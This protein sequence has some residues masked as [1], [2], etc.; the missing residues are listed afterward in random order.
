[1]NDIAEF[2]IH[3]ILVALDAST[4]SLA[5]LEEAAALASAMQAEL[6]GL[7][8]EDINLVRIA[9]L[10]FVRQISFPYGAE[11]RMSSERI[12]RELKAQAE[13]ARQALASAAGRRHTRWSFRTVRGQVT[14]EILAAASQ[15]DLVLLGQSG[16]SPARAVGST[17]LALIAASPGAF[18]LVPQEAPQTGPI[19]VL[20]D[21]SIDSPGDSRRALEAA[22]RLGVAH[23]AALLVLV[24]G[25]T[26]EACDAIRQN[27]REIIGRR[28]KEFRVRR[29]P[30]ATPRELAQVL[31]TEHGRLLV[32]P[33]SS[34]LAQEA[35]I[36][37]LLELTRSPLLL[38]R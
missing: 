1:M 16:W 10:P 8:V 2:V 30:A 21:G 37:S 18:L 9:G 4:P 23:Q 5:A 14:G 11:E 24:S 22:I 17:A 6:L 7:F 31:R 20:Y 35:G 29:V 36:R 28:V 26:P 27:A 3:R 12:D 34:A 33:G 13:L 38:I 19:A 25:S 15:T 32:L